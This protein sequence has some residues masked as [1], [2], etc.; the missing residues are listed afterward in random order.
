MNQAKNKITTV[1][2]EFDCPECHCNQLLFCYDVT[3][4]MAFQ[5]LEKSNTDEQVEYSTYNSR[6]YD[7]QDKGEAG[8]YQCAHCGKVW[9]DLD[10]LIAE[11]ALVVYDN[12]SKS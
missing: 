6:E 1:D 8:Y 10:E 9:S 12:P 4:R 3:M 5:K 7:V 2:Y 11:R